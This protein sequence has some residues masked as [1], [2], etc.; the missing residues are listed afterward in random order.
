MPTYRP[1]IAFN[2]RYPP[3]RM[4][5]TTMVMIPIGPIASKMLSAHPM[6]IDR[7]CF[8]ACSPKRV[9]SGPTPVPMVLIKSVQSL[10]DAVGAGEGELAVVDGAILS[11]IFDLNLE[12]RPS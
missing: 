5:L 12:P 7:N 11:T 4:A 10:A 8:V 1:M 6:D 2:D 3:M 9:R